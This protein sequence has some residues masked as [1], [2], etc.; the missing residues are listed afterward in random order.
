MIATYESI[1]SEIELQYILNLPEVFTSK[2]IID[3]KESGSINFNS[4]LTENIKAKLT[5]TF[6][7]DFSKAESI[8]MRWIK[9]DTLRHEDKG[10]TPFEKT[11]LVYINTSVGELV[12]NDTSYP[13]I[14]GT[15]YTFSEGIYHET[16]NTS[17]TPRLL[18]GPMSE[19]GVRVG[20][21]STTL[22]GDGAVDTFYI[23]QGDGVIEIQ[24][25]SEGWYSIAPLPVYINNTNGNPSSN[26]LK[27][28]FT[29]NII[30]DSINFYFI[31]STSG[32]QI[33][34]T[35]L[36]NGIRVNIDI[37][38]VSNFRGFIENGTEES[39]GYNNIYVYNLNVISSNGSSLNAG[40]EPAGWLCRGYFGRNGINNYILNCSST[41]PINDGCGGIIG[42]SAAYCDNGLTSK[43]YVYGCSSSGNI[44]EGGGGI[45]AS[46]AAVT[47]TS[48][49]LN[50]RSEIYIE[51]CY[52][53]GDLYI[54]AGGIVGTSAAFYLNT[55]IS[56]IKCYSTG[57]VI[58]DGGG[59][60]VGSHSG[61]QASDT[62]IH[63][64][65][66]S[67]YST[68]FISVES[69]GI[70]GRSVYNT[71]VTNCYSTGDIN[72]NDNGG[73]IFGYLNFGNQNLIVNNCYVSGL[74]NEPMG[75]IFGGQET[76][77]P[78]CYSEGANGS[79]GWNSINANT[80]LTGVPTSG[81]IG[82]IWVATI[83]DTPYE[84][85]SFGY[86]PYAIDN[87]SSTPQ[88]NQTYSQ[89]IQAG[90]TSVEAINADASG[91]NFILLAIQNGNP[92]SYGSITIS[93]L[94]GVISTTSS[95]TPAT[96]T[97][98]IRSLGS[99]NIT[100]F[101]LTI[102][103][104]NAEVEANLSCCNRPMNLKGLDY[105]RRNMIIAGNLM[106]GSTAV[107]RKPV[108]SSELLILKMAYASKF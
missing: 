79:Y 18:I 58:A 92:S 29:T 32:I 48:V 65:I 94:T 13:I 82:T 40:S 28:I 6:N 84:F 26:I 45:F 68:G 102:A 47:N 35:S 104:D 91:N 80:A 99:Y 52:S 107:Q 14:G 77:P 33:G 63:L 3:K 34:S 17:V 101:N 1:F 54:N 7:N 75:Y 21:A 46:Y 61:Y 96:Y 39:T 36:I 88:L 51:Q 86:T 12:L 100:F 44:G 42:F 59:G 2:E 67:C 97:L 57:D 22:I 49:E 50:S 62:E 16:R 4:V 78:S 10:E 108:S 53:T 95:T 37:S 43:L 15:G 31:C 5:N 89:T 30:V 41:G 87:I 60:I 76:V 9:G 8:P 24:K 23:H 25:N 69:G 90:E 73:G 106:H 98:I 85:N 56:V 74:V 71:N 81:I 64:D 11:Y 27:V 20:A 66:D 70:C 38:G 105:V 55:Y 93:S 103:G 83:P 72:V 19:T